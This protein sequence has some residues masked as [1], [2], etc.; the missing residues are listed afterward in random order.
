M[1]HRLLAAALFIAAGCGATL[2]YNP[3]QPPPRAMVP[4]PADQVLM[5]QN[6]PRWPF[7]E[8]GYL[9]ARQDS[10]WSESDSED[11]LRAVRERAGREGCEA[12]V[13]GNADQQVME[14]AMGYVAPVGDAWAISPSF[15]IET[16]QGFRAT[17]LVFTRPLPLRG[18]EAAEARE[19]VRGLPEIDDGVPPPPPGS[20]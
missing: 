12:V 9:G 20:L 6:Y 8:V 11:L 13:I 1:R 4:K 15:T 5:L 16:L 7:V 2:S 17:C 14:P 3:L 19:K 18:S 10:S